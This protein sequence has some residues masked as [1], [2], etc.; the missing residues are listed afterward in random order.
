MMVTER[1]H[2]PEIILGLLF[3][4]EFINWI[5]YVPPDNYSFHMSLLDFFQP[6]IVFLTSALTAF[7]LFNNPSVATKRLFIVVQI[8]VITIEV[9]F[10]AVIF[11]NIRG[12]F[13][14][15]VDQIAL[16]LVLVLIFS[17]FVLIYR[18]SKIQCDWADE[19]LAP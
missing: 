1:K 12:N 16:S 18:A 9:V 17:R 10:I 3:L 2:I 7:L 4:A 13:A 6:I 19:S 14:G 5:T 15:M 8:I 11:S